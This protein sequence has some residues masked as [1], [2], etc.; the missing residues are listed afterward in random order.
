MRGNGSSGEAAN[1]LLVRRLVGRLRG[2]VGQLFLCVNLNGLDLAGLHQFL[3]ERVADA[4]VLHLEQVHFLAVP[5]PELESPFTIMFAQPAR[6]GSD[7]EPFV[8]ARPQCISS[9]F[10]RR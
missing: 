5:I 7:E 9:G 1:L 6:L 2:D 10:C 4:H 3:H 8:C